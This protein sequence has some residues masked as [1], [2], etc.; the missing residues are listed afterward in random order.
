MVPK[1]GD[2][3]R[4][5]TSVVLVG[6]GGG[7][8]ADGLLNCGV[9]KRLKNSARNCSAFDSATWKFLKTE[10]S[11]FF[12][13]GPWRIL[14]PELPHCPFAS[15]PVNGILTKSDVLNHSLMFRWPVGKEPFP[16]SPINSAR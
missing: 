3:A 2:A 13:P 4:F 12:V 8:T 15:E 10:K 9:L 1:A 7:A 16:P 6:A 5:G 14:R 11:M